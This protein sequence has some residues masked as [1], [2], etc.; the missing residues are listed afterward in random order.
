MGRKHVFHTTAIASHPTHLCRPA[1]AIRGLSLM[2]YIV[3]FSLRLSQGWF[4]VS[5]CSGVESPQLF[6]YLTNHVCCI[7]FTLVVYCFC[8]ACPLEWL[9]GHSGDVGLLIKGW[10][11][12]LHLF[13]L[14]SNHHF[15]ESFS[16]TKLSCRYMEMYSLKPSEVSQNESAYTVQCFG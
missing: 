12:L 16:M 3:L 15:H 2:F 8:D 4:P 11:S 13:R 5:I 1:M 9:R 14:D 10:R 7:P 6:V